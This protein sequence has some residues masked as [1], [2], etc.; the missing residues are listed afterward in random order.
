MKKIFYTALMILLC[1]S[2]SGCG[3]F[4][5]FGELFGKPTETTPP[6]NIVT[7]AEPEPYPVFI[8]GVEIKSS[9][10]EIISLS[11]ALSEILFE[12][13]QGERL[14]GRSTFCDYPRELLTMS[15]VAV[16]RGGIDLDVEMISKLSPD[17]LLLSSP[18]SEKDRI[19]LERAGV[20]TVVIPAPR[21]LD[22]FKNV[23]RI[24]GVILYGGFIGAD[25]GETVFSDITKTCNNPDALNIGDFIYI[26][27]NMSPA[28]GDTL[29]SS[30]FSCFGKNLAGSSVGYVFDKELLL[31]KQPKIV[32]LNDIY[33]IDDLLNESVYSQLDAVKEGRVILLSNVY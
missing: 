3:F 19:T 15:D 7:D 20:V 30:V 11:P 9:P 18:I 4:G 21:N 25:E 12:F 23:Y 28:T 22:E 33:T 5:F 31:E 27:E 2:L 10:S 14:I 13:G 1:L 24:I 29:E 26:T 16:I 17:L 6:R 8:D 32:I